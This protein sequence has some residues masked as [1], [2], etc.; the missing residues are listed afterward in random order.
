MEKHKEGTPRVGDLCGLGVRRPPAWMRAA[1]YWESEPKGGG[2][3]S[4]W[5]C[6]LRSCLCLSE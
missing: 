1:W 2:E 4:E 6:G 5:G 3:G